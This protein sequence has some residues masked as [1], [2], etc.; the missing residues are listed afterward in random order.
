MN[1]SLLVSELFTTYHE[2]IQIY[3]TLRGSFPRTIF[4]KTC[5]ETGSWG[6]GVTVGVPKV[7]EPE[8]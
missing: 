1:L 7:V 2:I 5:E 3:E 4:L 8:V 6:S